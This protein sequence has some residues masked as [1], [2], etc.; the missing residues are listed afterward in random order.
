MQHPFDILCLAESGRT[1]ATGFDDGPPG[2]NDNNQLGC[3]PNCV[4][5][6]T[7]QTVGAPIF[8]EDTKNVS[9]PLQ[10]YIKI[11]AGMD[12][13]VAV[14]NTG[15]AVAWGAPYVSQLNQ[16]FGDIPQGGNAI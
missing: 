1:C 12:H 14:T 10:T 15:L 13:T 3:K 9:T 5:G 8:D 11:S 7:V 6:M 4:P 16:A 2:V